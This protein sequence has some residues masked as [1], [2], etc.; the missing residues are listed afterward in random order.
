MLLKRIKWTHTHENKH[1]PINQNIHSFFIKL[2]CYAWITLLRWQP[3]FSNFLQILSPVSRN[4]SVHQH[5][6]HHPHHINVNVMNKWNIRKS[7]SQQNNEEKVFNESLQRIF[8]L[9]SK[10]KYAENDF[11]KTSERLNYFHCLSFADP[12]RS[13]FL[14]IHFL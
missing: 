8:K 3:I 6:H 1:I 5:Q 10:V 11:N 13:L 12:W 7:N 2:L 9:L 14:L 4:L